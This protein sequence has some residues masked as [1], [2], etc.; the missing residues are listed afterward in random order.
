MLCLGLL[1]GG[2]GCSAPAGLHGEATSASSDGRPVPFQDGASS[3]A[4]PLSLAGGK[5]PTAVGVPFHDSQSLPAGTLLTVRLSDPISAENPA[6]SGTFAAVLDEPVI[7]EGS[8]LVPRGVSVAGRVESARASKVKRN[9]GYVR[10]TLDSIDLDGKDL[11]LQTSSLFASG[12][13]V[14]SDVSAGVI[15]LEK[16]RRLTFR[17]SEPVYVASRQPISSR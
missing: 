4:K 5:D 12:T 17:L 14:D 2:V 16:G 6:T 7:V 1:L 3:T 15:R 9:L 10:L 13:A 8:A 11:A